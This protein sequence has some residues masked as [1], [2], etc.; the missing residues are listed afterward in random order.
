MIRFA[1]VSR[2]RRRFSA[3]VWACVLLSLVACRNAS[4]VEPK[5]TV[6]IGP[7]KLAVDIYEPQ[8][9][10]RFA[11]PAVLMVH[12]GG[13]AA[14]DRSELATLAH[15]AAQQGVVALSTDYRL[16]RQGAYWPAQA[17]DVARTLQWMRDHAGDLGINGR[18]IALLG[19][20]AGGHLAAWVARD[21]DPKKRPNRLIVL[22]GPWDLERL[23]EGGPDWVRPTVD[24][25][26]NGR[27]A[28]EASPL[29]HLVPDMP[30]TLIVHGSAD[31]IVPVEQSRSACRALRA[32]GN[33][34]TLVELPGQ[35]H[36]PEDPRQV[37]RAF[38]AVRAALA[39]L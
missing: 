5:Q 7:H 20:S 4:D 19:G 3:G 36:A 15:M 9:G 23:P 32:L 17:D 11:R 24:T 28:R 2:C 1:A 10:K 8:A 6:I 35:A 37:A 33:D 26:L 16:T 12:G 34:C 30:P 22:W 39:A 27:P 21:P 31:E 14:G 13:W 18:R 38:E 29:H 25:L